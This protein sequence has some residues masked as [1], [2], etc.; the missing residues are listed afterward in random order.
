MR[1]FHPQ[2]ARLQDDNVLAWEKGSGAKE[3]LFDGKF[4]DTFAGGGEDGVADGRSNGRHAGF[5]DA[6][7]VPLSGKMCTSIAGISGMRSD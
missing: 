3:F 2:T 4:A 1:S 5:A 7:L 6:A